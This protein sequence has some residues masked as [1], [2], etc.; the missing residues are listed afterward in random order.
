MRM[1]GI[2]TLSMRL[3]EEKSHLPQST[4][5]VWRTAS[6]RAHINLTNQLLV[7]AVFVFLCD[8][9]VLCG[10]NWDFSFESGNAA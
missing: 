5:R 6:F 8:L 10:L 1:H 4:Q 3:E 9:C 7:R 2:A